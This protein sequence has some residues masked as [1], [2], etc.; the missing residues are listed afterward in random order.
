MSTVHI[1]T[2]EIAFDVLNPNEKVQM[3]QRMMELAAE[4]GGIVYT[5]K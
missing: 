2:P 4:T 1:V 5:I 3:A